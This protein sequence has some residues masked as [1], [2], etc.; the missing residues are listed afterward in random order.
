MYK[1]N[2][3]IVDK[4]CSLWVKMLAD[5]KF[6]AL[7]ENGDRDD[8]SGSMRVGQSMAAAI[9]TDIK[10]EV[11]VFERFRC[12]LKRYLMEQTKFDSDTK[13]LVFDEKGG[14]VMS[15]GVDYH[16]ELPL[17]Q[18]AYT[19]GLKES[20]FPW[21]THMYISSEH[22]SLRY[23]YGGEMFYYYPIDGKWLVTTLVGSDIEK[24]IDYVKGGKP[25][26]VL[27]E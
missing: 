5:P 1:P 13:R 10:T 6:D 19:A 20:L 7:G 2:E 15:L 25:E 14:Y 27:A 24:V 3:V 8:P 23:G 4:A 22:L 12:E 9:A 17:L 11:V 21:K 18:A 16:P 26:F